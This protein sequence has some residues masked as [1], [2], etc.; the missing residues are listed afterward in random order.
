MIETASR[1]NRTI[2][3]QP[4]CSVL[5]GAPVASSSGRTCS[6]CSGLLGSEDLVHDLGSGGDHWA[7]LASVYDLRSPRAGVPGQPRDLLDGYALV[8]HHADERGPQ[9]LRHPTCPE[10]S[11]RGDPPEVTPQV[12]RLISGPHGRGEHQPVLLPQ[13]PGIG[14]LPS[15]PA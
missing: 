10:P 12:M 15:L 11:R 1:A 14:S 4:N 8:A 13:L 3:R 9:L 5:I 7:Q 2:W 6:A